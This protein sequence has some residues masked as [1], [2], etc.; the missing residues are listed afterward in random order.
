[1]KE[2]PFFIFF[3]LFFENNHEKIWRFQKNPIS[4]HSLSEKK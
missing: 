2:T 4:L 3:A 1:M